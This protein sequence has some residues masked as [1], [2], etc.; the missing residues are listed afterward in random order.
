MKK[1]TLSL[2]LAAALATASSSA[3]AQNTWTTL[4]AR[5]VRADFPFPAQFEAQRAIA[6]YDTNGNCRVDSYN[7]D[8]GSNFPF[9][10]TPQSV[11]L[12]QHIGS[13]FSLVPGVAPDGSI[14]VD[15]APG[16]CGRIL[17]YAEMVQ[18]SSTHFLWFAFNDARPAPSGY[19]NAAWG[20]DF[21]FGTYIGSA[22]PRTASQVFHATHVMNARATNGN[23]ADRAGPTTAS[24]MTWHSP[25]TLTSPGHVFSVDP[26]PTRPWPSAWG[27]MVGGVLAGDPFQNFFV[28]LDSIVVDVPLV[29]E[30]N[31]DGATLFPAAVG[32]GRTIQALGSATRIPMSVTPRAPTLA[33][34]S[35]VGDFN[36]DGLSDVALSR[37]GWSS[38]PIYTST[39][40]AFTV[41][42]V[43]QASATNWIN[44]PGAARRLGDFDG[45][46]RTDVLVFRPGLT[47]TPVYLSNGVGGF[48]VVNRA[49]ASGANLLNDPATGKLVGDFNADGCTD[50]ALWREGWH[51]TPVYFSNCDGSFRWTNF[52]NLATTN[53]IND[54]GVRR[55]VGDFN[56]DRRADI[57]LSRAGWT[58]APV[59][60]SNGGGT[61][62]VTNVALASNFNVLND[63]S[64]APLVG[65]F[66][67]DGR[68]DI[69]LAR[70]GW[71]S[72]PIYF[73]LGTGAFRTTNFITSTAEIND[74]LARRS[75]GDFNG[76]GRS[77]VL[78]TRAGYATPITWLSSGAGWFTRVAVAT[79]GNHLNGVGEMLFGDFNNDR[80]TDVV[81]RAPGMSS[82]PLHFAT[83]GGA[84]QVSYDAHL[85]SENW[86]NQ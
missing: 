84:F 20:M 9:V 3:W 57:L 30:E 36:G 8:A 1:N 25:G 34:R 46:R 28:A 83:A 60:F 16:F 26:D 19:D 64:A 31:W 85:S 4:R 39:G 47:T 58:S 18:G 11:T 66:D 76:D 78:V 79:T 61:F 59:Y 63:M 74:P 75:V 86:I 40:S 7:A 38:T 80:R 32:F 77:D 81:V 56:G 21:G 49:E 22:D 24:H 41:T 14:T 2:V 69:A 10:R 51:S 43:A 12:G 29:A 68:T 17:V 53:W 55:I 23:P 48:R 44:D 73:S 15:S 33:T 54:P 42:N 13:P 62:T 50:I 72:T 37:A 71:N 82:T 52:A 6:L 5:T 35:M 27:L 45:D 67:A 65:D 70:A